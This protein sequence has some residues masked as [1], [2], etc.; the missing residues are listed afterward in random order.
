MFNRIKFQGPTGV[1]DRIDPAEAPDIFARAGCVP[2]ANGFGAWSPQTGRFVDC[3]ILT[4]LAL[5]YFPPARIQGVRRGFANTDDGSPHAVNAII[6]KLASALSVLARID[7]LY[8][9]GL[10]VGVDDGEPGTDY[11]FP[12]SMPDDEEW[13][14]AVGIEDGLRIRQVM[15]WPLH[16]WEEA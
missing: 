13:R 3:C 15:G 2:K 1:I 4:A 6:A 16:V 8:G 11:P 9:W 7:P 14:A 12:P 5:Y 10:M